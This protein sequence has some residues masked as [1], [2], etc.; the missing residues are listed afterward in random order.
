MFTFILRRL[1]IG[2]KI[3][4]YEREALAHEFEAS[5][6]YLDIRNT[7]GLMDMEKKD[8]KD[9]ED[10]IK[11]NE[12]QIEKYKKATDVELR[13]LFKDY[14]LFNRLEQ[15]KNDEEILAAGKEV[16][17]KSVEELRKDNN[18]V[19]GGLQRQIKDLKSANERALESIK[20]REAE[21]RGIK[22]ISGKIIKQGYNTRYQGH[23]AAAQKARIHAQELRKFLKKTHKNKIKLAEEN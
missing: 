9:N 20:Q 17:A 21:L 8:I 12:F 22:E 18:E 2:K 13:Q 16:D 19:I 6:V 3:R 10:D 5:E 4:S 7:K 14:L 23:I 15:G 11:Q 1:L